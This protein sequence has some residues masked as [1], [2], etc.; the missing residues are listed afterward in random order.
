MEKIQ[1]D[2]EGKKRKPDN[3]VF[4]LDESQKKGDKKTRKHK[5]DRKSKK[6]INEGEEGEDNNNNIN[7]EVQR[8]HKPL[9]LKSEKFEYYYKV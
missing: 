3:D 6:V 2:F 9:E 1:K 5:K 8:T 4:N 7:K